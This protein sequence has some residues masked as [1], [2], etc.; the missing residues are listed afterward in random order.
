M[1]EVIQ[2]RPRQ[3]PADEIVPVVARRQTVPRRPITEYERWLVMALDARN[4]GGHWLPNG[5]WHAL[6]ALLKAEEITEKQ[7]VSANARNNQ[8]IGQT[9]ELVFHATNRRLLLAR[10]QICLMGPWRGV[11]SANPRMGIPA[12]VG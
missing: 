12:G 7:A 9:G 11:Y 10:R 6:Q 1:G 3:R 8:N 4:R 2:F 5:Q